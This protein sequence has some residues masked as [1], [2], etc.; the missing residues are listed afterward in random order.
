MSDPQTV[1]EA[2]MDDKWECRVTRKEGYVGILTVKGVETGET[3]LCLEVP[4]SYGAVMG[5]DVADVA[6]WEIMC[7]NAVD[8]PATT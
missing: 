8:G 3:A 4:L 1:W 5:P 2:T 6:A 7:Q